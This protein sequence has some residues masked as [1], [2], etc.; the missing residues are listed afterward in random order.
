MEAWLLTIVAAWLLADFITGAVHWLED[1]YM[2]DDTSLEFARGVATDNVLHHDKPTAMTLNTGWENMRSGAI[3]AWP[4]GLLAWLM[5][6]PDWLWMG[7]AFASLGNLIHRFAHLPDSRLPRWI[8]GMQQFGLFISKD[9]HATHH[10]AM[11][12][13]V[14]KAQAAIAYCPMTDWLNPLLDRLDFWARAERTIG[15]IG[16]KTVD[17]R[18]PAEA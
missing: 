17:K 1:R 14:S 8:K 13:R 3:F 6:A 11:G 9:H 10:Y 12:R 16:I 7:L 4:A 2:D 18:N 5:G 15:L